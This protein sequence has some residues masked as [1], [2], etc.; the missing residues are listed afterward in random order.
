M[1]GNNGILVFMVI[2]LIIN[3][4]IL[5]ANIGISIFSSKMTVKIAFKNFYIGIGISF[6]IFVPITMIIIGILKN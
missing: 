2:L 1:I 5:S 6:T 3:L 4:I